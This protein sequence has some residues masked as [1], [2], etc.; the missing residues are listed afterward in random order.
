M[1]FDLLTS[2]PFEEYWDAA[3]VFNSDPSERAISD[4]VS[5][6]HSA[7]REAERALAALPY[8]QFL[9]TRYWRIVREYVKYLAGFVCEE[10]G[11]TGFGVLHVHHNTYEHRGCE[12]RYLDDLESLCPGCHEERHGI[13][14]R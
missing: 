11:G 8:S 14:N 6:T 1:I 5:L 4:F 12:W 10:C 3:R 13:A 7:T 2:D 9:E